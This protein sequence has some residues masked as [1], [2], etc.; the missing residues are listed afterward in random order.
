ML[1]NFKA[2]RLVLN[3]TYT[4]IAAVVVEFKAESDSEA[5]VFAEEYAALF[6]RLGG[7]YSILNEEGYQISVL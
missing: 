6:D 3:S 4:Y 7:T 2:Y 5:R 1:E